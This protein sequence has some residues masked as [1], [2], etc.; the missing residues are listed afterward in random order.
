MNGS[1]NIPMQHVGPVKITGPVM[2]DEIL[3]P[4]ATYETPLWP[5]V[6]RGARTTYHS[7]GI[8]VTLIDERMSRSVLLEATDA[9]QALALIRTIQNQ[10]QEY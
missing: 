10:D 9:P 3:V 1:A 5:S 2:D 7:G 8:Q 4:L 6:N